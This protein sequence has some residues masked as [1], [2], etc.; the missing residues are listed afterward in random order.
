MP[1]VLQ[2]RRTS[3]R[4]PLKFPVGFRSQMRPDDLSVG[5]SQN[6]SAS[7]MVLLTDD[8]LEVSTGVKLFFDDMPGDWQNRRLTGTIMGLARPPPWQP[9]WSISMPHAPPSW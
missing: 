5:L 3:R 9:W 1:D 8:L 6:I 7:G 2:N 4:I